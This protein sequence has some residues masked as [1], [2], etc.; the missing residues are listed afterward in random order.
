MKIVS[1]R[2]SHTASHLQLQV[3][4]RD[5]CYIQCQLVQITLAPEQVAAILEHCQCLKADL[6]YDGSNAYFTV[7]PSQ[8]QTMDCPSAPWVG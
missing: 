7:D 2:C 4:E 1:V 6:Q 5:F 8:I 3:S